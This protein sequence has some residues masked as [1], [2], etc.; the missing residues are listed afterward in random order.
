MGSELSATA[1]LASKQSLATNL[2]LSSSLSA[3]LQGPA[4]V[5][6]LGSE[7][8]AVESPSHSG[9]RETE[10][11][12]SRQL[13]SQKSLPQ[14]TADTSSSVSSSSSSESDVEEEGTGGGGKGVKRKRGGGGGRRGGDSNESSGVKGGRSD[15]GVAK[16]KSGGGKIAVHECRENEPYLLWFP[17]A[18]LVRRRGAGRDVGCTPFPSR[19]MV[20]SVVSIS[21]LTTHINTRL[22]THTHTHTHA[23]TWTHA[24]THTHTH[25]HAH[26]PHIHTHTHKH[27]PGSPVLPIQ[28]GGLKVHKLGKVC[29]N[30]SFFILYSEYW[31]QEK[32]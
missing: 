13:L 6:R 18:L 21:A 19:R 15:E 11:A 4:E 3:L 26:T 31:K 16:N 22:Y 20:S 8:A 17:Q 25:T 10:L 23:H 28:I 29:V 12:G 2:S 27:T 30:C 32:F 24:H 14:Q 1:L 9:D 5:E 7:A